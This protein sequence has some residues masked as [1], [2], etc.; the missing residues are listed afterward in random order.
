MRVIACIGDKLRDIYGNESMKIKEITEKA[1]KIDYRHYVATLIT[2]GF[3]ALGYLFVNSIPRLL[4]SLRDLWNSFLYL[5]YSSL[6]TVNPITVTVVDMPT[7]EIMSSPFEP[8]TFFPMTW[9][10]FQA[11]WTAYWSLFVSQANL[12][13]FVYHLG[14]FAQFGLRFIVFGLPLILLF[15]RFFGRY[16]QVVNNDN[17]VDSKPLKAYKKL[18]FAV[19]PP[20]RDWVKDFYGFLKENSIYAK[21]WVFLGLIYFNILSIIIEFIAFYLYFLVSYSIKDVYGQALKLLHDLTPMIRF[22]PLVVWIGLALIAYELT[23]RNMAYMALYHRE[24]CNRGFINERGVVTIV[25]GLMGAGKTA[26]ITDMA[27]SWEVQMRDMAYEIMLES[28]MHFPR[29]PW[30]NVRNAV[31][32]AVLNH[33]VVDVKSCRKWIQNLA[34]SYA[35]CKVMQTDKANQRAWRRH[36]KKNPQSENLIFGYDDKHFPMTYNDN[37]KIESVWQAIENYACAYLIYQFECSLIISN[38]SIRSDS[39]Q[40]TLGNLPI[41]NNDFFKRDPRFA[42]SISRHSHILDFDIIRLGVR[43][44]KDNPRRNAFGFG[45]YVISEIDKERKNMPELQ[46]IDRNS[47]ECNQRNDLFNS[48]L[49]MSRHAVVIANRVFLKIFCDLQ[50]PEDWG[51]G[52]REVGEVV[53]IRDETE[54]IPTLPFFSWFWL[55]E[56]IVLLL[57]SRF[58]GFYTEYEF[59]RADNTLFVYLVK[60]FVSLL[61]HYVERMNNLFGAQTL[62]LDVESARKD[63]ESKQRKYYRM[64]KKIFSERYATNCLSAIFQQGEVNTISIADFREYAGKMATNEELEYQNSH[65]QKDIRRQRELYAA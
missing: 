60:G 59:V 30:C 43:M 41:W 21:L 19:V 62:K 45:C 57:K 5:V 63:G 18:V 50:R 28:D 29:F 48:C 40:Q 44:L 39:I 33:T 64:P 26:L 34:R 37:L 53:F 31:K 4:E 12:Q 14:N 36:V 20:V 15:S 61:E 52:G 47:E 8:L 42:D 17:N 13:E 54:Q 25:Y 7:W 1:R 35:A 3:L 27:L 2:I 9:E 32:E 49:K 58:V 6:V 38:Y 22:V 10:E 11:K 46:G 51:A 23:C 56:K 24:R 65:F 16:T 55:I